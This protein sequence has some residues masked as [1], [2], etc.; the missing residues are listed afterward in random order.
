M[1]HS[2]LKTPTLDIH[3][4]LPAKAGSMASSRPAV[5]QVNFATGQKCS[6]PQLL[7]AGNASGQKHFRSKLLQAK[8]AACDLT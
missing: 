1:L 7:Q 8:G 3:T 4:A 5:L 2:G 6:R